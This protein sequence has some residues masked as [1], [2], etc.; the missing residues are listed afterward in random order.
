MRVRA[1]RRSALIG[2]SLLL[3]ACAFSASCD[4]ASR[5]RSKVV[6][7]NLMVDIGDPFD[8]LPR[9]TEAAANFMSITGPVDE[10]TAVPLTGADATLEIENVA[11]IVQMNETAA[12]SGIYQ[13]SSGT[14]NPTFVYTSGAAYTI[15]VVVPSGKFDGTYRT[16]VVAPP[17]TNVNGLPDTLGGATIPSNTQ[18]TVTLVGNYDRGFVLVVDSAGNVTYDSRPDT[19]QE[20]VDF[21]FE[22]FG[23]TIQ[24]PPEAFPAPNKLYGVVIAGM[25]SA[26][27][28]GISTN[29]NILT[30]FYAG[31]AKTAVVRTAP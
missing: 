12:G 17:R 1:V 23:G 2:V 6:A 28:S 25:N 7:V 27:S 13:A 20:A 5:V 26:P 4:T 29:L 31:A 15:E 21:V 8:Q 16:T 11:G 19:A 14:G 3:A 24:I 18:L 9:R 22:D 10:P 30:R